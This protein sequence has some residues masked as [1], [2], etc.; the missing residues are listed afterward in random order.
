MTNFLFWEAARK[1]KGSYS[2]QALFLA[3]TPLFGST[4]YALY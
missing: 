1:Q 3:E 2:M 4:D